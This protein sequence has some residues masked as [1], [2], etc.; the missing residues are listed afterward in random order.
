MDPCTPW[1]EERQSFAK[2]TTR[3]KLAS[4]QVGLCPGTD[5]PLAK[6]ASVTRRSKGIS[7]SFAARPHMFLSD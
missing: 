6:F 3:V 7:R 5:R 2:R 1:K 4:W